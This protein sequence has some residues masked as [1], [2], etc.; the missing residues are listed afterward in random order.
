[1]NPDQHPIRIRCPQD[2]IAAVPYI[3]GFHPASSLVTLGFDGTGHVIALRCDLVPP[4]EYAILL[5][6]LICMLTANGTREVTLVGYGTDEEVQ[7]LLTAVHRSV[8][9]IFPVRDILRVHDGR[10]WP[11]LRRHPLDYDPDGT[12]FDISATVV[13]AQATLAGLVA[14]PDRAELARSVA[15]VTGEARERMLAA[16]SRAE[17]ELLR[18]LRDSERLAGQGLPF[19]TGILRRRDVLSD[20][21]VARLSVILTSYRVRDE[22]LART[23]TGQAGTAFWSDVT[24]RAAGRYAAAPASLLAYVAYMNGAGTLAH[25]ALDRARDAEPGYP[26]AARL[27]YLL[28]AGIPPHRGRLLLTPGRISTAYS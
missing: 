24:R 19:I 20:D 7:P 6:Q 8:T 5:R 2:V 27:R 21:E 3:L 11:V 28:D 25:I 4:A 23:G 15:A 14:W 17:R 18:G 13:A 26:M 22:A 10:W 1:M 12:P 16:T 9:R